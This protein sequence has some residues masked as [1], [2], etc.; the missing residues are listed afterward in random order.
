MVVLAVAALEAVWVVAGFLEIDAR[1]CSA[2]RNSFAAPRNEKRPGI[3]CPRQAAFIRHWP[4]ALSP[5]AHILAIGIARRNHSALPFWPGATPSCGGRRRPRPTP[6][7]PRVCGPAVV[8]LH[9]VTIFFFF[10]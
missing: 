5:I 2:C 8:D 3:I 1:A 4:C 7:A 6:T 10:D 9:S